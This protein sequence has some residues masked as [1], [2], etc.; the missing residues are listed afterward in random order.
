MSQGKSA[1][2]PSFN[3][4]PLIPAVFSGAAYTR[5]QLIKNGRMSPKTLTDLSVAG[6]PPIVIPGS[7]THWYLGDDFIAY[8]RSL[9]QQ[10]KGLT[11]DQGQPDQA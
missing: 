11:G 2:S 10:Q 4:G 1:K 8:L 9:Q 7:T 3:E 5:K 6:L